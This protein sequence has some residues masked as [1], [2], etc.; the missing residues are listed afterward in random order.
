MAP[1]QF[2]TMHFR[3]QV[4]CII[5]NANQ[6]SAPHIMAWFILTI[7]GLFE[8]VWAIGLKYSDGFTRPWVVA[9]TL[10][11][12]VVSF[13]LLGTAMRQLPVGTAYAVW[14]GIGALGTA[15][16]GIVLFAEP[17]TIARVASLL[18]ILSGIIGLRLA[19]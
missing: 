11:A 12:M 15:I 14:T 8:V 2:D 16:L 13:V 5:K 17:I 3:L 7:A 9:G 1:P 18:L 10:A 4:P 19:G 6:R